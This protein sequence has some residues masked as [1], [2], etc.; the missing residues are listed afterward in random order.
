MYRHLYAR[1]ALLSGLLVVAGMAS[2]IATASAITLSGLI[3]DHMV[4]QREMPI[5]VWGWA[6]SGEKVSVKFAGQQALAVAD[7]N[8]CWRVGLAPLHATS[9]SLTMSVTAGTNTITIS[10]ILVGDVWLCSGQ[11]N[12]EM[13]LRLCNSPEDLRNANLPLIRHFGVFKR[14]SPEPLDDL[15]E[16]TKFAAGLREWVVCDPQS[17]GSFTA[18]GFYFARK[19]CQETGTPIGLIN[20]SWGAVNIEPFL[21]PE[22]LSSVPELAPLRDQFAAKMTDYRKEVAAQLPAAEARI[23]ATRKALAE[24]G[25]LPPPP[26]WPRHPGTVAPGQMFPRELYCVYNGMINPLRPFAIKGALWY[27]GESNSQ[28]GD[29]YYHKMR[30]LIGGWRTAWGQGDFP[31]YYVQLAAYRKPIANPAGGDYSESELRC[32]QTKALSIP[33][34]GMA[35]TIDIGDADNVHPQNKKDVGERL[36][37]WALKYDYGRTALE[38]S[39]PIFNAMKSEGD[40][41]RI[42]FDH[43]GDGLMVGRKEGREPVKEVKDGKLQRFAVAGADGKWCWAEAAIDGNAVVVS[44]AQVP[45]PVTVR[46]AYASNPEGCNLY[47]RAGLPASPFEAKISIA[48]AAKTE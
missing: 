12:M 16:G 31:F 45:R 30:A 1:G 17:A 37:L 46:Y 7:S 38:C 6:E 5:S 33:R 22:S 44:S 21:A 25:A 36:A 2:T 18:V 10:D 27:Q 29:L 26:R 43:A 13:P 8:G 32:V 35:V 41:V 15:M 48:E 40:K 34:T 9:N 24:N 20:A 23:Q 19:I 39:G 47:N 4:L 11:S 14:P 28:D 42:T 3:S